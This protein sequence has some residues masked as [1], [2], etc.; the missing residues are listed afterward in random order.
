MKKLI[1]LL[2]T[3]LLALNLFACG[4]SEPAEDED[5]KET[6]A[7]EQKEEKEEKNETPSG[8]T[9]EMVDAWIISGISGVDNFAEVVYDQNYNLQ[10]IKG[11]FEEGDDLVKLEMWLTFNA[12]G[13]IV[14]EM[15]FADYPAENY[16]GGELR[17]LYGY[18]IY[19]NQVMDG[20]EY[21]YD[22]SGHIIEASD[23]GSTTY[24]TYDTAGNLTREV[25][26]GEYNNSTTTYTYDAK[27]NLVKEQT[28]SWKAEYTYNADG[29]MITAKSG[30][31]GY[32]W[33]ENYEYDAN[34]Q[35]VK[36]TIVAEYM[37]NGE[38]VMTFEYKKVSVTKEQAAA[39]E[40]QKAYVYENIF[41]MFW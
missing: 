37:F 4:S 11:Q 31:D 6:K 22:E 21:Q 23:D 12:S 29:K 27:G 39:I 35:L 41:T 40:E 25:C 10:K 18:D 7:A 32:E 2:L 9:A 3:F 33:L 13:K 36:M 20:V 28:D 30:G 34:G 17:A 16:Y 1:A 26:V 14:S 15:M 24:Y 8:A 38:Q 5:E 19:G